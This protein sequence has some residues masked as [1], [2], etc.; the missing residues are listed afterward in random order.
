MSF[1]GVTNFDGRDLTILCSI[2]NQTGI[3]D[4]HE[5]NPVLEGLP[6]FIWTMVLT[7]IK[8]EKNKCKEQN[9][10]FQAHQENII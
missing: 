4:F 10:L 7:P 1:S 3:P 9:E 5:V 6:L 8:Y 2:K